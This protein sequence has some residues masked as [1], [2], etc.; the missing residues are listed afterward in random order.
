MKIYMEVTVFTEEGT[1]YTKEFSP[2]I[3]DNFNFL[4]TFC[5]ET[6]EVADKISENYK[7]RFKGMYLLVKEP[8]GGQVLLTPEQRK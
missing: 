2:V 6:K 7:G 4:G 3:V 5:L 8:S 1:L